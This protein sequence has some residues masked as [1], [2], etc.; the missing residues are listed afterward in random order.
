MAESRIYLPTLR[1]IV[2]QTSDTLRTATGVRIPY[3]AQQIVLSKCGVPGTVGNWLR[4]RFPSQALRS[5]RTW[6]D[7]QLPVERQSVG[8][9]PVHWRKAREKALASAYCSAAAM[10]VTGSCVFRSSWQAS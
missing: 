2:R 6:S 8:V 4:N 1:S 3:V 9:R 10:W 7:V 5:P